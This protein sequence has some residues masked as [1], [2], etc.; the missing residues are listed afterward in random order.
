MRTITLTGTDITTSPLGLGCASMGSRISRAQGLR[1]LSAAY[2]AG[3]TWYDVAPAYGAGEAEDILRTFLAGRRDKVFVCSKV[4]LAPPQNNGIIK[5][6]YALGRPFIGGVQDLRRKFRQVGATRNVHVTLTPEL[7]EN[8]LENSLRRLGTDHLDVF[9][10]H[11]PAPEDVSRE[12]VLKTLER[13]KKSGK[14]RYIAVAGTFAAACAAENYDIIQLADDPQTEPLTALRAQM[15]RL[16]GFITHSILGI[17]GARDRFI[18]HL[19]SDNALR[20]EMIAAGHTGSDQQIATKLL[21]RRAFASN[22]NGVVL[23]SMFSPGNLAENTAIANEMPDE[24]AI[25]LARR[26][27]QVP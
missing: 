16:P 5:T 22:K 12:D 3:V 10:L 8:S 2:D 9:A 19:Q 20:N 15:P 1:A 7:I 14:A 4:G 11:D 25:P 27:F 26:A 18:Q 17:G 24:A 6:L 21:M 23:A 13:I